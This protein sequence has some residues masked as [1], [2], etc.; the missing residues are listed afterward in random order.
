MNLIYLY[1]KCLKIIKAFIGF[2]Y[3]IN[4]FLDY[5]NFLRP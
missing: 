4:K 1:E 3:V 5:L 2:K